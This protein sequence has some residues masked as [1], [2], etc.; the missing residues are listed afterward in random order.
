MMIVL[1]VLLCVRI[2]DGK[3]A[4]NGF[5]NKNKN[6][7]LSILFVIIVGQIYFCKT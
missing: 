2:E 1:D 4:K 7:F 5:S 6:G 3:F